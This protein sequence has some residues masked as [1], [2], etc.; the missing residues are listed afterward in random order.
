[1]DDRS[2]EEDKWMERVDALEARIAEMDAAIWVLLEAC[3]ES[4]WCCGYREHGLGDAINAGEAV[5]P[6]EES[7]PLTW[8]LATMAAIEALPIE[9]G[10]A[11]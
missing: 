9:G 3:K 11:G 10:T 4:A 8:L 6:E 5:L 2:R 1:M 7:T